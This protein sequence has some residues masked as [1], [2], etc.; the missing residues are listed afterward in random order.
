MRWRKNHSYKGNVNE[1]NSWSSKILHSSPITFLIMGLPLTT[2]GLS[3]IFELYYLVFHS[4]QR[5]D[6]YLNR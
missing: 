4:H 2:V 6:V 5:K 3:R 1:K